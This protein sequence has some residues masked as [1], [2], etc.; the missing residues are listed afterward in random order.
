MKRIFVLGLVIASAITPAAAE[1]DQPEFSKPY[2]TEQPVIE[3]LGRARVEVPPNRAEF[4]I[5]FV[6]TNKDAHKAMT[7]S[8]ERARIAFKAIKAVAGDNSH[9]QTS[10]SIDPYYDQYRD[11]SGDYYE[12]EH[13]DKIRGYRAVAEI[14]VEI[15]DVSL[16]GKAR[17]A[18]LTLGPEDASPLNTYLEPTT[19]MMR[20]AY[21]AAVADGV[22]RAQLSASASNASLGDLLVVQE[23]LGPCL[24]QWS[25]EIGRQA[26]KRELVT[27]P[28]PAASM[29]TIVVSGVGRDGS[30][31]SITEK[32]IE[33]LNL[34]SD[35][36]PQTI[37][38]N[39][40]LVYRL[41][42]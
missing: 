40:C 10:V 24:G 7:E 14:S 8:V 20:E 31:F 35:M 19:E 17:G 12:N 29:D 15:T 9:V 34:P 1:E 21:E 38:A 32:D 33:A 13:P 2:W 11:E 23:G 5:S 22:A 3:A 37:T 18:A 36:S 39:V 41:A 28:Q 6:E 27:T 26:M 4:N 30:A 25:F 42:Q 16:A